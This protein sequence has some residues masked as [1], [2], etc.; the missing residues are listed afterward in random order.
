MD[1]SDATP[2]IMS[3]AGPAIHLPFTVWR[4]GGEV[5]GFLQKSLQLLSKCCNK[6]KKTYHNPLLVSRSQTGSGSIF[7][8]LF[9]EP[10]GGFYSATHVP[11]SPALW[12]RSESW[13]LHPWAMQHRQAVGFTTSATVFLPEAQEGCS[14]VGRGRGWAQWQSWLPDPDLCVGPCSHP[15][16]SIYILWPDMEAFKSWRDPLSGSW[17]RRG[18]MSWCQSRNISLMQFIETKSPILKACIAGGTRISTA[19]MYLKVC[20]QH[21]YACAW[22]VLI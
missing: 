10:C 7:F 18:Q 20:P 6:E 4:F 22:V 21:L 9:G 1:S 11:Q 13:G 3:L 19:K 14:W 5:W 12:M 2:R 16:T 8:S 15:S 17:G